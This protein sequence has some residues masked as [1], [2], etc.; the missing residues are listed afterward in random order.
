MPIAE[1]HDLYNAGNIPLA[2][3]YLKSYAVSVGAA[4][5][6]EI[7]IVPRE[8]VNFGGDAAVIDCVLKGAKPPAVVGFTCYMW[9]VERSLYIAKKLKEKAPGVTIVFGGPE[10]A[11]EHWLEESGGVVDVVVRGEG[12]AAFS[13]FL[14]DHKNG[15]PVH[16]L[17][18]DKSPLDLSTLPNPYLENIIEPV[19]REALF[20]E[21]M[22]GCPYPCKY[23]FY[24]KSYSGMRFLPPAHLPE[25][26]SLAREKNVPELY[27]MD[28]SFNVTP[29]LK[30][31]LETMA[32]F[33]S[34]MI[35]MHTE[36]RLES[37][38]PELAGLMKKAG[39]ASVEAGL[40]SV[41]ETSLTLIGRD[42]NRDKFIRGAELLTE[43]E[44]DVKTG[45]ILGLPE[46]GLEEFDRTLDFVLELGLE[47]S[48]EIYPLSLIPG[49]ALRDEAG[50]LGLKHMRHP[51]YWVLGNR[52][53]EENDLKSAIEIVEQKLEIEFFPPIVP[54]F[55]NLFPGFV[56]FLDIRGKQG[57]GVCKKQLEK[58]IREPQ[59][60]GHSLT[61]LLDRDTPEQ[62]LIKFG[63]WLEQTSPYTLVQLVFDWKEIP[64]QALI[65]QLADAFFRPGHY[66]NRIHHYKIDTQGMY[67][68]RFFHLT[69]DLSIVE[70]YLY[71][72]LFCD[73][74][75]KYTTC[76]LT[77]GQD[78]LEAKPV[79]WVENPVSGDEWDE[80]SEIYRDFEN[81]C[82][83]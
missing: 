65:R 41:N 2:A 23:C 19:N 53:L 74:I 28:P 47:E 36:I 66:F 56:H 5:K 60:V 78:I 82:I 21:T 59:L 31:R 8:V 6:E 13:R 3:G 67:S 30:D 45:V 73:V 17:Y 55:K 1:V 15:G 29:G 76:L 34:T 18:Y 43:H 58:L 37:V 7:A 57:A 83:K 50:D 25:L 80:L 72:P 32:A 52:Y 79:V 48:M 38:T 71:E 4:N 35:P 62:E 11:G 61:I 12:E 54:R 49:T 63:K 75:V 77:D 46:D 68:L 33:N 64:G 81:L 26:F 39:F 27:I 16:P 10:M 24:S 20:I 40:Q 42:W 14:E 9:N 69:G 51:P 70:K 44:I 22:R